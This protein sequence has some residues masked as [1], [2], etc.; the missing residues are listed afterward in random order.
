M[1]SALAHPLIFPGR[2]TS[3]L[4]NGCT[5]SFTKLDQRSNLS[6]AILWQVA[7]FDRGQL[8]AHYGI[9]NK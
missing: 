3:T 9:A 6:N 7:T 5:A 8:I 1:T 4:T 2:D